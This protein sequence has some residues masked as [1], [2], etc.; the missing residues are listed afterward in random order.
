MRKSIEAVEKRI[1]ETTGEE[2]VMYVKLLKFY[3]ERGL[4]FFAWDYV[5]VY[6]MACG[7]Y[8]ILQHAHKEFPGE[9]PACSDCMCGRSK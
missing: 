2:K 6:K 4:D 8:E 3:T 7:H 9:V 1:E 5:D